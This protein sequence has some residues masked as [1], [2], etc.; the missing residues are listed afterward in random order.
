MHAARCSILPVASSALS[1]VQPG[2]CQSRRSAIQSDMGGTGRESN[3]QVIYSRF[4]Q[5]RSSHTTA[6]VTS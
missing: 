1:V 6:L 5:S 4:N 3:T 2:H